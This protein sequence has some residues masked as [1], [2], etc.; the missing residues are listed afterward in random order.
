MNKLFK[1]L[2]EGM[3]LTHIENIKSASRDYFFSKGAN[4]FFKSRYPEIGL[5]KT[6]C[7]NLCFLKH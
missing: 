6:N 4:S 5:L 3:K 1:N 7:W 2:P